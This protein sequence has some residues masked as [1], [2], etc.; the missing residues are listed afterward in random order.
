[1]SEI[2]IEQAAARPQ[3][4]RARLLLELLEQAGARCEVVLPGGEVAR[5]GASPPQFRVIVHDERGL[6]RLDELSLGAAYVDGL[7][8]IEGDML[9]LLDV[10]N[11]LRDGARLGQ[12]L[13]FLGQLFLRPPAWVNRKAIGF[14]YTLGDDFYLSFI[15]RAYR[16]YSH[17]LFPTGAETLEEAAVHKLES[18]W[19]A[20]Q[21]RP[22][23]RLLDIGGGW[24]GVPEYCGSRGVHVTSVTLTQDSHRYITRLIQ[25]K[26]LPCEVHLEDFLEHRP[27][28][29]YD[30]IVIYGV[31]EHIPAYRRFCANAWECLAPGGRLYMDASASKVKFLMSAFTRR[32]IWHGTHTFLA[33]QD[34]VDELLLHGFQLVEVKEETRDYELTILEWARRIDASRD[35]IVQ[36]WGAPL[37]RAFRVY[38]WGGGHAFR[39]DRLQAYHLVA[40]RGDDPGPRPGN[41][42]RAWSFARSLAA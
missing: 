17:C 14:H 20:L 25:E 35:F 37:W 8:D 23:M 18:M 19:N 31:I 16:F 15:D 9:A 3:S 34:M 7:L 26:N 1:M 38:L 40:R 10:R 33:V 2:L 39:H 6:A 32:Y 21:L 36:R 42:R 41:L 30:A 11:R 22:G 27:E 4:R 13:R 29:P 5:C 24:G 28:K 12:K